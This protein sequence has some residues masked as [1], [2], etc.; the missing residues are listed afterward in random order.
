MPVQ[1]PQLLFPELLDI[2]LRRLLA[3]FKA[4][5]SSFSFNCTASD[6]LFCERWIRNTIRNVTTVVPVLMTSCHVSE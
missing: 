6:S 4:D 3:P 5:T 2:D 1:H